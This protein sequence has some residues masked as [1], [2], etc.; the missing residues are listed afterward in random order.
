MRTYWDREEVRSR[1]YMSA[2]EV[3]FSRER[4]S[5]EKERSDSN[6]ALFVNVFSPSRNRGT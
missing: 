4:A 1:G 2:T 3:D 6:S 5:L